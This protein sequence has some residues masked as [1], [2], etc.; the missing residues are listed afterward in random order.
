MADFGTLNFSVAFAP[1]SAFPLDSRSYFESLE[2]AE[3][4]AQRAMPAG[5]TD[6]VYYYGQHIVVVAD[7]KATLYVIQPDNTLAEVGSGTIDH[8]ALANRGLPDQH[9]MAAITG[10]TDKLA[11]T[12]EGEVITNA[13][14]ATIW[15]NIMNS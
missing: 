11:D 14:I 5:S 8:S 1:T 7:G 9:P 4:A 13:E 10:L 3:V 6:S 12:L 15:D 2:A